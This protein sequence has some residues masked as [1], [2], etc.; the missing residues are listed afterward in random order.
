MS[1]FCFR[2]ERGQ[3]PAGGG[4]DSLPACTCAS[5]FRLAAINAERALLRCASLPEASAGPTGNP[6]HAGWPTRAPGD[7]AA[8]LLR[9][10]FIYQFDARLASA[11]SRCRPRPSVP[12]T[13]PLPSPPRTRDTSRGQEH[14]GTQVHRRPAPFVRTRHARGSRGARSTPSLPRGPRADTLPPAEGRSGTGHGR[15][16]NV[17]LPKA[18]D[19][20]PRSRSSTSPEPEAPELDDPLLRTEGRARP[21]PGTFVSVPPPHAATV[22]IAPPRRHAQNVPVRS[23]R[24]S[25][26][27]TSRS[28]GHLDRAAPGQS[29]RT[30]NEAH[31][32]RH[33]AVAGA[34]DHHAQVT[35]GRKSTSCAACTS[36][37]TVNWRSRPSRACSLFHRRAAPGRPRRRASFAE[38]RHRATRGPSRSS[39]SINPPGR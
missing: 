33:T 25:G 32:V 16:A 36:S 3:P 20:C 5:V 38:T 39:R 34:A 15:S 24:E 30:V 35:T 18:R 28:R 22:P 2:V 19:S 11:R 26:T 17:V 23:P 21:R 27:H 37:T 29:T 14:A 4:P 10:Y 7:G 12:L 1:V 6:R 13:S 31:T 9:R 8:A